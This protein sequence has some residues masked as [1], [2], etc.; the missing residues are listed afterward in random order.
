MN[1]YGFGTAST[2]V[3]VG[4]EGTSALLYPG[5]STIV[6][7]E[8]TNHAGYDW[9][10]YVMKGEKG[11]GSKFKQEGRIRI[12]DPRSESM[13]DGNQAYQQPKMENRG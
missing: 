2:S 12:D 6:Q 3:Y 9:N 8:F 4:A 5:Q 10:L 13:Y 7:I 1:E 11:E